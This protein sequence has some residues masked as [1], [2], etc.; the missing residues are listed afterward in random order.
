MGVFEICQKAMATTAIAVAS[1]VTVTTAHA[2]PAFA[3]QTGMECTACH[4]SWPELTTVGRQ[5][6]LGGYTLLR[7]DF[8]GERPLVS[9]SYDSNPPLLPLAAFVQVSA[10]HMADT[11]GDS[12]DFPKQNDL[13]LQQASLFWAGRIAEHAGAFAQ[14]S[15]DGIAHHSS[16]DNFDLRLANRYRSE[17]LDLMYGLSFN[18]NPTMSDIYQT[19]PTWGFPFS[20]SPIAVTPA[21]ATMI[22]GGLAQQVAGLSVYSLWNKT[23]YAE[24]G[25]YRTADKA[26]SFMRAGTDRSSDAA[27]DGIAPYWRL[28]LQH[29]WDQGI[30]SAMIGTY[31]LIA[32]KYPDNQ[33]PVGPTDK[34][35]DIGIDAQYQYITDVHRVGAQI[36]YIREKQ[37]WNASFAAD[38]GPADSSDTLS[39]FNTKLTY[40][41]DTKYG[42]TLSHFRI[43]GDTDAGLYSVGPISGSANGSPDTSGYVLELNWLPRRDRRFVLQYTA[44]QKFNGAS[45][46]YDGSGRDAKDNNAL[47]LL[48]W[49][50][51]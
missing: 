38:G 3:R 47:Y 21:A 27:L 50:P 49:F 35:R 34:F 12:V 15:Y 26:F 2:L 30:H 48:A 22:E 51:F 37:D 44:Y 29:E 17:G 4:L 31:G 32:R 42:I 10:S 7:Q 13:V 11:G 33:N 20:A 18:N 36:N 28:S 8:S 46:N 9:F 23:V 41:L 19:T 43:K 16:I 45:T 40:Y 24:F 14:W 6:K 39:S 25:G 1:L 5:F